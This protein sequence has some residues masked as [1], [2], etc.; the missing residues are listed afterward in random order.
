MEKVVRDSG[1]KYLSV[2][3]KDPAN[4]PTPSFS[5]RFIQFFTFEN[6][7]CTAR[8]K[9]LVLNKD[10]LREAAKTSQV[11]ILNL[12]NL[13]IIYPQG[14]HLLPHAFVP[15]GCFREC[16]SVNF[17][18]TAT[19]NILQEEVNV[20]SFFSFQVYTTEGAVCHILRKSCTR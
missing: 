7:D 16:S 14:K 18:K 6:D 5:L 9:G 12:G 19:K 1:T 4:M 2:K 20:L 10:V 11:I 13:S 8:K 3:H 15:A 17:F